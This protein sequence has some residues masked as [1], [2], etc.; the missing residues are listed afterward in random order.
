VAKF[1]LLVVSAVFL[2][3]VGCKSKSGI[4]GVCG[5]G[6]PPLGGEED[7]EAN[8]GDRVFF[9]F[10]KSILSN[11]SDAT[12]KRQSAWLAKYPKVSVLI[13]G[14][15]DERGTETYNLALGQRRADAVRDYLMT[16]GVASVRIITVSFGK[17][18]PIA[19]GHDEESLQQNRN[20]ITSVQGFNPYKCQSVVRSGF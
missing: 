8:V 14:N 2:V 1:R 18:C 19:S 11:A 17:D 6:W 7:L 10:D 20:A 16:N 3:L 5:C 15:A 13:A 4:N 9:Q 12:L